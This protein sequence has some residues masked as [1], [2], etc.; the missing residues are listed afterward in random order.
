MKK[1]L[2]SNSK[3]SFAFKLLIFVI[4]VIV[5]DNVLGRLLKHSYF[6]Q[7]QGYDYLTTLS[8]KK[9]TD[10]VLIFG[11]S[12]AVNIINPLVLEEKLK[13]PGFNAGRVG[14]SIFYHYGVLK[15]VLRRYKPELVI[16]SFDAGNFEKDQ[17]DYDRIASLLP[18]YEFEPQIE[19]IIELKGP[20]EKLKTVSKIYPYNSMVLPILSSNLKAN[21]SKYD[22]IKGYIPLKRNA[23]GPLHTMDFTRTAGIDQNKVKIYKLFIKECID[24]G[25]K[26]HIVCPPYLI[27]A[28]G[29]DASIETAKNIAKEFGI[30]FLDHS[31]D[32][33]YS[34]QP[35]LFADF[36]HLNEKGSKKFTEQ[37][38]N[39][40]T[41]QN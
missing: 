1:L 36:R 39:I 10:P 26:L 32:I 28:I 38:T 6:R 4:T 30:N 2:Q 16:L 34:Q 5:A 31:R 3:K 25:I 19:P 29:T 24:A 8:I 12:R 11:S 17:E 21:N 40:I 15:S 41:A 37:I 14:Q 23:K 13:L 22:N 9:T 7:K 20:F 33:F 27:N 35:D 18:Y